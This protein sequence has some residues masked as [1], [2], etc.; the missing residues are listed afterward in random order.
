MITHN[1]INVYFR[2]LAALPGAT[3]FSERGFSA[4]ADWS[5]RQHWWPDFA[6]A[7]LLCPGWR[8]SFM[9]DSHLFALSL[10]A[11][12]NDREEMERTCGGFQDDNVAVS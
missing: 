11:F 12:L 3:V 2:T 1:R 6:R 9:G 7:Y 10:F 8:S 4:L 5:E